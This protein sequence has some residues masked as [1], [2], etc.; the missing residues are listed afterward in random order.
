MSSLY[1]RIGDHCLL[2][3]CVSEWELMGWILAF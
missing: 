3:L 2:G 1:A